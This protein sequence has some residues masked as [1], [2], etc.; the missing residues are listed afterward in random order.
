MPKARQEKY[1]ERLNERKQ[2]LRSDRSGATEFGVAIYL[3]QL[4]DYPAARQHYGRALE[5]LLTWRHPQFGPLWKIMGYHW[6]ADTCA[7]ADKPD[8]LPQW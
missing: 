7:M 6:L 8:L 1:L 3:T 2:K 4:G 5:K